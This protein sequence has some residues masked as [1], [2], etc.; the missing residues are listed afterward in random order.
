MLLDPWLLCLCIIK[1]FFNLECTP[2]FICFEFLV[3]FLCVC[4]SECFQLRTLAQTEKPFCDHRFKHTRFSCLCPHL[5]P[6]KE[7]PQ[8]CYCHW[9]TGGTRWDGGTNFIDQSVFLLGNAWRKPTH[10]TRYKVWMLPSYWM[11]FFVE[12]KYFW[13]MAGRFQ[14]VMWVVFWLSH[15]M[16]QQHNPFELVM[17]VGFG[18]KSLIR[19]SRNRPEWLCYK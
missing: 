13:C 4:C 10:I 18:K 11:T 3:Y 7:Q 1:H 17:R 12:N 8:G 6:V 19:T 9:K 16:G 14:R 15:Q 2:V 5:Y